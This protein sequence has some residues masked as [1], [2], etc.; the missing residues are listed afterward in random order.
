MT[1]KSFSIRITPRP[2]G[3][4]NVDVFLTDGQIT[5][6]YIGT[7][8]MASHEAALALA[9]VL[10][11]KPPPLPQ[12]GSDLGVLIEMMTRYQSHTTD[13]ELHELG[14]IAVRHRART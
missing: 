14:A 2:G 12:A 10:A 11:D 5:G 6:S 7:L 8:V 13:D 4:S 3:A 1:D 9:A